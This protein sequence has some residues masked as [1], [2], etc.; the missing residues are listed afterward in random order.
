MDNPR[1]TEQ[2]IDDALAG[3]GISVAWDGNEPTGDEV[4]SFYVCADEDDTDLLVWDHG[5][6]FEIVESVDRRSY[7]SL[8]DAYD[9]DDLAAKLVNIIDRLGDET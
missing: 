4:A 2:R 5:H 7:V 3:T 8:Q 1:Y 9:F 6:R